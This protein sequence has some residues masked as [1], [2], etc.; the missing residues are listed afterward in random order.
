MKSIYRC[1]STYQGDRCKLPRYH[2]RDEPTQQLHAGNFTLWGENGV[3]GKAPGAVMSHKR[4]R[5]AN[6]AL[7]NFVQNAPDMPL[8]NQ[9]A[10][11]AVKADLGKLGEFYGGF[12]SA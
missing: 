8:Y 3:Q 9:V 1:T 2:V 5:S 12:K 7:L 10:R 11:E 6:R 4:N